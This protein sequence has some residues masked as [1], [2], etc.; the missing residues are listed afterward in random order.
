MFA[1]SLIPFVLYLYIVAQRVAFPFDIEWAEGAAFNQVNQILSGNALYDKPT[2]HFA[3]LVYTPFYYYVSAAVAFI[4]KKVLFSMRLVSVISSFGSV[5]VFYWLVRRE[6]GNSFAGWISGTLFLACFELSNG[7]YDLARVDSLYIFITLLILAVILASKKK[8]GLVSAGILLAIAFFTKQSALIIFFPLVIYFVLYDLKRTWPLIV[9]AVIG[10]GV[11]LVILNFNSNGWFGYYIF[12]LPKNHGYSFLDAINFWVGDT[13]RPLG[14]TAGF[15]ILY[16]MPKGIFKKRV[17][18]DGKH[19]APAE[20][21]IGL[22]SA[23]NDL[24]KST[25]DII[26]LLFVFGAFIAAWITRSSNGGGSNNS[27]SA[28]SAMAIMF[29]LGYDQALQRFRELKLTSVLPCVYISLLA[30]LQLI[31]LT[32]NPFNYIPTIADQEANSMLLD[33]IR[34]APGEVLIPYRSHLPSLA[35]KKTHIHVVNLFEI[36]GYFNG[37]IQVEGAEIINGI[38]G[39][40][41]EQEYAVIILDQPI[42][43]FEEQIAKTYGLI[44]ESKLDLLGT[45]SRAMVWQD[46]LDNIYI[47]DEKWNPESCYETY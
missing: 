10:V 17:E 13:L 32:Y 41:C 16:F 33:L 30:T 40:I 2:N 11:P 31:S 37:K 3:P 39:D 43:W 4:T 42:P 47:P 24:N 23:R 9:T 22:L 35:D 46:G 19:V 12:Q 14:I 18:E 45:R 34:E 26:F 38:R 36:T 8:V 1:F 6:T 7:F 15:L 21:R 44:P 28:Y 20:E 27:M 25:A 5:A 29:G